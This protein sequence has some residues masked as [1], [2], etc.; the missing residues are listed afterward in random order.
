[1]CVRVILT[2]CCTFRYSLPLQQPDGVFISSMLGGSTLTE[3]S[4]SLLS[5]FRAYATISTTVLVRT[6][7]ALCA[8]IITSCID[9]FRTLVN[10]ALLI[11]V[12][13][14]NSCEHAVVLSCFSCVGSITLYVTVYICYEQLRACLLLAEQEREGGMSVHTSPSAHVSDCGGLLGSASFALTTVDQDTFEVR[15]CQHFCLYTHACVCDTSMLY[16]STYSADTS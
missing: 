5:H 8:C 12:S 10:V 15:T 14:T 7:S 3:A 2:Y 11:C 6:S 16:R 1:M 4:H 13:A 9:C